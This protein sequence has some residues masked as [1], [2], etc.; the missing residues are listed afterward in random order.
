LVVL[1]PPHGRAAE[2]ALSYWESVKLFVVG[3]LIS[4]AIVAAF[5]GIY[6][7]LAK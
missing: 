7:A 4:V 3:L 2:Q 5:G 1:S 6:W